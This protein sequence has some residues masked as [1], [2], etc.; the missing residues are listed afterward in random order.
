[1]RKEHT[2][3]Q[4][5][6]VEVWR[7]PS[8]L[9]ALQS[10]GS[11]CVS[12]Q[13]QDQTALQ[14]SVYQHQ[15][16]THAI[17]TAG[18]PPYLIRLLVSGYHAHSR[19]ERMSWVV[20]TSLNALVQGPAPRCLPVPQLMVHLRRSMPCSRQEDTEPHQ[21]GKVCTVLLYTEAAKFCTCMPSS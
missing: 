6:H 19:N 9:D 2:S 4:S 12:H 21:A 17:N 7:H 18:H 11:H 15:V 10:W 14:I 8:Q 3:H 16:T 5:V 13:S 20:H 1:M